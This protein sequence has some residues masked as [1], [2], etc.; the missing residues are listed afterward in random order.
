MYNNKMCDRDSEGILVKKYTWLINKAEDYIETH[1]SEKIT[2]TDISN[3]LG[4]SKYHFHRIFSQGS[5]ET[6][7]DFI[8]R[9]KMERSAVYLSVN[10]EITVTEISLLYGY[11]ESSAYNR[12]F[13][14][15]FGMSPLQFRKKQE[16]SR[17]L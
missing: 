2:L 10:L 6:L 7:S 17:N 14:K 12:A 13:K 9:I 11:S 1:L 4:I 16:K 5:N 8:T 15:H 3:E